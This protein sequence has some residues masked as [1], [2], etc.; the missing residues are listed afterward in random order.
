MN[1]TLP[2]PAVPL[3]VAAGCGVPPFPSSLLPAMALNQLERRLEG[4]A[5]GLR[6]LALAF[7][8]GD[9]STEN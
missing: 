2:R 5:A 6:L 8:G 9:K 1:G 7:H 4:W 3:V